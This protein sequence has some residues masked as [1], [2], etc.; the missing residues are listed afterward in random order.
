MLHRRGATAIIAAVVV[1][2]AGQALTASAGRLASRPKVPVNVFGFDP[3]Y[4]FAIPGAK[5]FYQLEFG[6]GSTMPATEKFIQ[7]KGVSGV[8]ARP[9]PSTRAHGVWIWR[10]KRVR[11]G[12]VKI[13]HLALTYSKQLKVN[14]RVRLRV[15]ISAPGHKPWKWHRDQLGY[16]PSG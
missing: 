1:L 4:T 2:V 8:R 14:Q 11:A 7:P 3:P 13:V 16:I 15:V 10:F 9:K 6:L 5:A 12:T